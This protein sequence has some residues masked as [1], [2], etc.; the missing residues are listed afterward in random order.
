MNSHGQPLPARRRPAPE[1]EHGCAAGRARNPCA[2]CVFEHGKKLPSEFSATT[3]PAQKDVDGFQAL[4]VG[5]RGSHQQI[6][7]GSKPFDKKALLSHCKHHKYLP[8]R[9]CSGSGTHHVGT[10]WQSAWKPL[11]TP[12]PVDERLF[13][14]VALP[15][16]FA[17]FSRK[18]LGEIFMVFDK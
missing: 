11:S 2:L 7:F 8:L 3:A 1:N 6:D 15:N 18:Y 9:Q 5:M 4:I 17:Q 13:R 12:S 14:Q 10:E 16:I